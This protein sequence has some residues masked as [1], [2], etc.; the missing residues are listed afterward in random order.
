MT[1]FDK[2]RFDGCLNLAK[3]SEDAFD[4][5]RQYEWKMNFAYWAIIL[6]S[7]HKDFASIHVPTWFWVMSAIFFI[8]FWLRSVW[9]ANENDKRRSRHFRDAAERM[10][11]G[12]PTDS[13]G[14]SPQRLTRN[15]VGWWFGFIP[16]WARICQIGVTVFLIAARIF[17]C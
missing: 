14:E 17:W 10:L 15:Q 3:F 16:D 12:D 9:V 4:R 11:K 8:L 5:R 7:M 13:V 2:D 1:V 6:L